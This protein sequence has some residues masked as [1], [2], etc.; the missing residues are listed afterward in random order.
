MIHIRVAERA[1]AP[2]I[3]RVHAATWK[4]AYRG[5]LDD[6]YLESLSQKRLATRWRATL[7]HREEDLD[8]QVFVA[9]QG[10]EVVGFL[11]LGASREAFA[12][13]ESEI[14]MIYVL[15][16]NRGAGIGRVLMKAA[17]DHSIR[18]GMF[19]CGLWVLRDNGGGRDFYEVLK[20]ETTGRKTD[21]VGGQLV[22]LVAY[23]WRDVATLADRSATAFQP[24]RN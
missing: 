7:D 22:Q 12:P 16:E 5:I 1:D 15:K 23:W 14:G 11:T 21:S 18:R 10:R 13:W 6:A 8:E 4:E 24:G 20:G 2:G 3:A 17:A 19:S 9:V